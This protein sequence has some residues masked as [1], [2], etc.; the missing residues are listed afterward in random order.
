[1]AFLNGS[2]VF[3]HY[4]GKV[5]ERERGKKK[6]FEENRKRIYFDKDHICVQKFSKENEMNLN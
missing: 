4:L 3:C 2:L 1:M 5:T 6:T